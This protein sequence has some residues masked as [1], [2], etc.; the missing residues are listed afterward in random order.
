M[1]KSKRIMLRPVVE[2]DWELRYKWLSDRDVNATLPSG[3]GLPLTPNAVRERT[4]K[5]AESND[6]GI[7]F[8][9]V[10]EDNKPI[11][12]AQLFKIDPWNRHAEIGLWIG[13]KSEWGK[14]YGTEVTEILVQFAFNR[15]NLHKVYLTVDADNV[16]AI[17]CYEK[18]GFHSDGILRDEIYKNGKYV[19]RIYMSLLKTDIRRAY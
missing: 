15:L 18:V 3:S 5:Y 19:N 9:I 1:I 12:N 11:G 14:G 16:G 17:R 8:T 10:G 13:E 2:E 7:Y 6:K 4:R